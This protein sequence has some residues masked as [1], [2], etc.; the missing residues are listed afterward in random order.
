M[1]GD[2]ALAVLSREKNHMRVYGK[3]GVANLGHRWDRLLAEISKP[4]RV[5]GKVGRIRN[6]F[7]L[8]L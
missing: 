7:P 5:R 8:F 6:T 3:Q 4:M 1:L 2:G